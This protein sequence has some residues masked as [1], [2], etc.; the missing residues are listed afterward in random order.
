MKYARGWPVLLA[1]LGCA[2]AASAQ[3]VVLPSP[4]VGGYAAGGYGIGFSRYGRHTSVSAYLSGGT[5]YY[6]PYYGYP[7]YPIGVSRLT[8]MQVVTPPPVVVA[9][10]PVVVVPAP[11]PAPDID[12]APPRPRAERVEPPVEKA[13]PADGGFRPVRPPGPPKGP[14]AP[15]A[16]PPAPKEK[17]KEPE[18]KAK[19]NVPEPPR[20]PRPEADPRAEGAR[21]I[22]LGR[23]AFA[24]GEYGRAAQRFRQ[25][26][27]VNPNDALAYFL[28]AQAEVA[29]GKYDQAVDAIQTGMKIEP[30]WPAAKFRPVQLYDGNV[31]D[32]PE[33]LQALEDALTR[34]PDDAVLLF[35]YAYELWFDGRQEEAR[36][37]FQR[38][39]AVAPDRSFSERF[40][41]AWP[42]R[43]VL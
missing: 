33:H 5:A 37:L 42:D 30:D 32:L 6:S 14:E 21:Q 7:Y 26:V 10:P 9:P 27:H 8:V 2:P 39:A 43:P 15:P 36:P 24:A 28:L 29:L 16:R 4:Y 35:L 20:P 38:A 11:A 31:A 22:G 1:L 3:F 34:H 13:P 12:V 23:G 19:P 17:P 40:L 18:P 41:L 25:A